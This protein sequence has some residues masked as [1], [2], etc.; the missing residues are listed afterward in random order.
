MWP[1]LLF[2]LGGLALIN[3]GLPLA[4]LKMATRQRIRSIRLLLA[5][6]VAVAIPLTVSR[7]FLSLSAV[8]LTASTLAGIPFLVYAGAVGQSIINRR[9]RRFAVLIG[10]TALY[11]AVIASWWLWHDSRGMSAFEYYS[12][13]G[14][15][16]VAIPGAFIVGAL[17]CITWP[18]RGAFRLIVRRRQQ[19]VDR[20]AR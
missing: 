9:F 11:A 17:A 15:Y 6:P 7:A 16:V 8:Q 10:L 12:W 5:I 2:Q 4:I 14:W 19:R 3:I 20:T 1:G 18:A 13:S